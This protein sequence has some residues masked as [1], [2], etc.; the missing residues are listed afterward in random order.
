ME[1]KESIFGADF[2]V[3]VSRRKNLLPWWIKVFAWIFLVMSLFVPVVTIFP[4]VG[5]N[6]ELALYGLNTNGPASLTGLLL[7]ALFLLKGITA[8]GLLTEQKWAVILGI[9][10]AITGICICT[11]VM[12][13]YPFMDETPGFTLSL[14]LELALLIPYL[15]KLNRIRLQWSLSTKGTKI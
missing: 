10:D 15:I 3:P 9:I 4:L 8:F 5:A 7:I 12:I 13:V 2:A 6:A 11:F 1:E 14:R